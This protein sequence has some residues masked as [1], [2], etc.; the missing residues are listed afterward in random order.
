MIQCKI[1]G[2]QLGHEPKTGNFEI[3]WKKHYSCH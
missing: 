1:C 2:T 3:H